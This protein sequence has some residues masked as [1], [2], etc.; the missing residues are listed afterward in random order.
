MTFIALKKNSSYHSRF[1]VKWRRRREGKTDYH[2]R[3]GLLYQDKRK[4][5]SPKFRIAVRKTKTKFIV[6]FIQS[7][8]EGDFILKSISPRLLK[9][10][11]IDYSLTSFPAAYTSGALLAKIM[12]NEKN[13]NNEAIKSII[14]IKRKKFINSYCATSNR[15]T[16]LQTNGRSPPKAILDIGL[17]NVTTGNK[18]FAVMK[19]A[20]DGGLS[21]PYNEKRFPG[22]NSTDGFSP[23]LL[24]ERIVGD[25]I[26][27]YMN[28][29]K[30]EDEERFL[31]QFSTTIKKEKANE[32][33]SASFLN[34][35]KIFAGDNFQ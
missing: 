3:K 32:S 30:D 13:C 31:R 17:S 10:Y 34:A 1:Q 25:H 33:Y 35:N 22:Y 9:T 6:Q 12:M 23:E 18:L 19:G 15:I 14:K 29:L 11:S 24:K 28:L 20:I 26:T 5:N 7:K 2:S 27:N 4:Y 16:T 21:I 8:L